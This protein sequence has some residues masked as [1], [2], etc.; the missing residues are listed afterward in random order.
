MSRPSRIIAIDG[1]AGA[2][3]STAARTLAKKLGFV[4]L[5]T[6][7]L[8]RAVALAAKRREVSWSDEHGCSKVAQELTDSEGL[9]LEPNPTG[10]PETKGTRVLLNE[11]DVSLAIRNPEIGMGAS[12]VSAFPGVRDALLDLQR[13]LGRADVGVVAEGRDIGTVVFPSAPVKFF[14]TASIEVRA[15][16]RLQEL[17]AKGQTVDLQSVKREVERRD[18]QDSTREVA[19]LRQADDAI[20]IDSTGRTIDEVVAQMERVVSDALG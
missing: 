10:P 2:G 19:P 9:R 20:L 4:L 17:E 6:G 11:D 14:L 13:K 12:R 15:Q 3:K 18:E 7:A 16:R 1:P 5:D 8:Y